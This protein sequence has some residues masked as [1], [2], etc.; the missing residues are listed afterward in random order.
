MNPA[1][2]ENATEVLTTTPQL[3]ATITYTEKRSGSTGHT[4]VTEIASLFK[5]NYC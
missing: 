3:Q 2:S 1:L 5:L 4:G